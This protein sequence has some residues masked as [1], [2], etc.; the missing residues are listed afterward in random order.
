MNHEHVWTFS[1]MGDC[2]AVRPADFASTGDV[3]WRVTE[4]NKP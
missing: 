3:E 2:C 4:E 1:Y